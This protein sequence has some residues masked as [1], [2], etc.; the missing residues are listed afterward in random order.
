MPNIP[1]ENVNLHESNSN[2]AYYSVIYGEFG[3]RKL[4]YFAE[5]DGCDPNNFDVE[6]ILPLYV[7]TAQ[8]EIVFLSYT[9]ISL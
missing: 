9:T 5:Q 3:S 4:L 2:M 7:H 8:N 1:G 6:N